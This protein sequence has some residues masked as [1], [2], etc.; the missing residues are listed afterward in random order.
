MNDRRTKL[1]VT[2]TLKEPKPSGKSGTVAFTILEPTEEQD[3]QCTYQSN[4]EAL[5]RNHCCRGKAVYYEC[6]QC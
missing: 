5:S 4:I 2:E 3:T 6:L 1:I